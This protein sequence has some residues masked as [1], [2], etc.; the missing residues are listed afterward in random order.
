MVKSGERWLWKTIEGNKWIIIEVL[1]VDSGICGKVVQ[2]HNSHWC[3]GNTNTF[4]SLDVMGGP[5][6][7]Y[8]SSSS[9]TLL[10]GQDAPQE[11]A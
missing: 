5:F 2:V 10:E 7:K 1:S 11:K 8:D 9:W 4:W 3:V 6:Q